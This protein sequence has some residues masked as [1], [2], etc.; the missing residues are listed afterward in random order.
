M[1]TALTVR[2]TSDSAIAPREPAVAPSDRLAPREAA[3]ALPAV[4]ST[5]SPS[6]GY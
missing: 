2:T 6:I 1:N 4:Y 5:I 3:T